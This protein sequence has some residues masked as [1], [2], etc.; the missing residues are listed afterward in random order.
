MEQIHDKNYFDETQVVLL[1]RGGLR[2][3]ILVENGI[4][5]FKSALSIIFSVFSICFARPQRPSAR[6]PGEKWHS[7]F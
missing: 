2:R 5:N 1:V 6:N 3:K 7:K 4:L